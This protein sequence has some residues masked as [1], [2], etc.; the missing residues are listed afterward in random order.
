MYFTSVCLVG[1]AGVL[2]NSVA[3]FRYHTDLPHIL[4]PKCLLQ[5][6]PYLAPEMPPCSTTKMPYRDAPSIVTALD[7]PVQSHRC[8]AD[9]LLQ[10]CCYFS[11]SPTSKSMRL[12]G[13]RVLT[14]PV[15]STVYLYIL[16]AEL[17]CFTKC[18]DTKGNG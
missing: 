4:P 13:Y 9:Y 18:I 5:R 16:F 11:L 10:R 2:F 6:C 8:T 14:N 3:S 12:H 17:L 15:H 7:A 1:G